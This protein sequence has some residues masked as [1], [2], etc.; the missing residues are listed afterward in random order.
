MSKWDHWEEAALESKGYRAIASFGYIKTSSGK[1]V[2]TEIIKT[3]GK[4]GYIVYSKTMRYIRDATTREVDT[5]K[6]WKPW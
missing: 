1:L 2:R 6:G 5:T 3:K 4:N